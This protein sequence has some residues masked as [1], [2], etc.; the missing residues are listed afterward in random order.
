[1]GLKPKNLFD[2]LFPYENAMIEVTEEDFAEKIDYFINNLQKYD[3]I[4]EKNYEYVMAN[5]RWKNRYDIM[6]LQLSTQ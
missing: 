3:R 4:V 1:M 5:H 6:I 2:I